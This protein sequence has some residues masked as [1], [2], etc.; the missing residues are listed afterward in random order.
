MMTSN[1]DDF[2]LRTH[3]RVGGVRTGLVR[4]IHHNYSPWWSISDISSIVY[5]SMLSFDALW[6]VLE[7]DSKIVA[8]NY[9]I[10]AKITP[11]HRAEPVGGKAKML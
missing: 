11:F 2:H 1:Y 10:L 8:R 4:E 3:M 9:S 7:L 5:P 6:E